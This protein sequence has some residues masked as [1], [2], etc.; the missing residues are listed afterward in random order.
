MKQLL[1]F[2]RLPGMIELY[3]GKTHANSL[4]P[5]TGFSFTGM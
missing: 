3:T 1:L 4:D 2:E 5:A